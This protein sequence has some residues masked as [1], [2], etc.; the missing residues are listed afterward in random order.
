MKKNFFILASSVL[1][2]LIIFTTCGLDTY[3]TLSPPPMA[4]NQPDATAT[5]YDAAQMYF[6]F[7]SAT[8]TNY[9]TSF[10]FLGTAVY[11][12]IYASASTMLSHRA[13]ISAVNTSSDYSAAANRMISYGYQQLYTSDGSIQPLISAEGRKVEIRLTNNHEE[14][15][16][17]IA[18]TAQVSIDGSVWKTPRRALG[19]NKTFDF[20]R[21]EMSK[22]NAQK[23]NYTPPTLGDEDFENGT[24]DE[25]KYYVTMYAVAVGRDTTY[26]TYYSNVLYLGSIVINADNEHN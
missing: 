13:S 22:Y 16:S 21:Y 9:D 5:G 1:F 19:T 10:R 17:G 24:A 14:V 3:Y 4:T 20:G 15:S 12:R 23:N 25:N 8:N 7:I 2:S 26:T 11:Y 6:G 18:N